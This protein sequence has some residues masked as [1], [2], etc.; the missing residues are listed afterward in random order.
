M[1]Y[2]TVFTIAPVHVEPAPRRREAVLGSGGRQ[3]AG[4]IGGEVRPVHGGGVEHVKVVVDVWVGRE[5]G[6]LNSSF[7]HFDFPLLRNFHEM[8]R[9]LL[10]HK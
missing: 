7:Y 4:Q 10:L 5:C 1:S 2:I 6:G 8:R 3:T 9:C